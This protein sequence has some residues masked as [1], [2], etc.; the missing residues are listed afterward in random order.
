MFF[1]DWL[2]LDA[3]GAFGFILGAGA[4]TVKLPS[5]SE[6]ATDP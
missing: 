4:M 1:F 5:S 6:S 3:L 2:H